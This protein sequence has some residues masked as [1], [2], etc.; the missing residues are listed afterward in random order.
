MICYILM[1]LVLLIAFTTT[2]PWNFLILIWLWS[3]IKILNNITHGLLNIMCLMSCFFPF[4]NLFVFLLYMVVDVY[5]ILLAFK[6]IVNIEVVSTNLSTNMIWI[7]IKIVHL[8]T[9]MKQTGNSQRTRGVFWFTK[10]NQLTLTTFIYLYFALSKC[11]QDFIY[12]FYF[13]CLQ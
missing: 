8:N 5:H 13:F 9:G 1:W 3:L 11:S 6:Y 4:I 2:H 12:C 7:E 10:P